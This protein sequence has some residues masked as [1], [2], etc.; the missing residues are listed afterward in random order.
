L[1]P[2]NCSGWKYYYEELT[3]ALTLRFAYHI[4]LHFLVAFGV[5][6]LL[7]LEEFAAAA[8]CHVL[9]IEELGTAA[10]C[11]VLMLHFL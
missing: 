8:A 5:S 4:V 3:L 11:H 9:L 10:A 6:L 1:A 7:L 2:P